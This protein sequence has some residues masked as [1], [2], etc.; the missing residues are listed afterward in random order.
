MYDGWIDLNPRRRTMFQRLSYWQL[1]TLSAELYNNEKVEQQDC[2][3]E[4]K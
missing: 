4:L 3:R 1:H 2:K